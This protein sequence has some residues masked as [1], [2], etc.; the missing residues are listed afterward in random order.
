MPL[1]DSATLYDSA[2]VT[3]DGRNSW[4]TSP[5]ISIYLAFDGTPYEVAPVWTDVTG[6]VSQVDTDRSRSD[7]FSAFVSTATV[8]FRNETQLFSPFNTS[9]TYFGKLIPRLQI[10]IEAT[11]LGTIYPVF[12]GFCAG[13]P[14]SNTEAGYASTVTV[15]CFDALALLATVSVPDLVLNA[16]T[17]LSPAIYLRCN[18]PIGSAITDSGSLA[19]TMPS[20]ANQALNGAMTKIPSNMKGLQPQQQVVNKSNYLLSELL[21]TSLNAPTNTAGDLTLIATQNQQSIV[22]TMQVDLNTFDYTPANPYAGTAVYSIYSNTNGTIAAIASSSGA[23]GYPSYPNKLI[24]RSSTSASTDNFIASQVVAA[25]TYTGS[26]GDL[27]LFI[28]GED[29]TGTQSTSGTGSSLNWKT[30]KPVSLAMRYGAWQ[31]VMYFTKKLTS[32]QI[33]EIQQLTLG[34]LPESS[35][36]RFS[37]II[38]ATSWS[39]SLTT[40][41]TTPVVTV[42]ELPQNNSNLVQ[43]LQRTADS[44]GG[45]MYVDKAGSICFRDRNYIYTNT[46]C[47][48]SQATFSTASIRFEPQVTMD[49]TDDNVRNDITVTFAGGGTTNRTNTAS[50]AAYGTNALSLETD[51]ST[52]QQAKDLGGYTAAV[53]GNLTADLSPVQVNTTGSETDWATLLALDLLDRTT[54]TIAPQQGSSFT[55]VQLLNSIQHHITPSEWEMTIDGSSQYTAFFILNKSSLDGSDL[56]I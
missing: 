28:N 35:S 29:K 41:S 55:K 6:Y 43:A 33:I 3:Y 52:I 38:A 49:L 48:T 44:E 26:T 25:M 15:Q 5:A 11:V 8:T 54:I 37:R 40:V 17:A 20:A 18:D 22:Q 42:S 50:I 27:Q 10:K 23:V 31:D 56:L 13:F 4:D 53:A 7:D 2:V 30:S 24:Q 39:S 34:S 47:N 46:S 1:Y 14:V 45:F 16:V 21:Y 19:I 12:R 9:G 51:L 32:A 36:A